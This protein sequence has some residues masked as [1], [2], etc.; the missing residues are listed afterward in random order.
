M[1]DNFD[2]VYVRTRRASLPTYSKLKGGL[3]LRVVMHICRMLL[4][5]LSSTWHTSRALSCNTPQDR[6]LT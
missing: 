2:E 3:E 5:Q 4:L 1:D 6:D